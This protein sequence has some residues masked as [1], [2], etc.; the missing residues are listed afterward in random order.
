MARFATREGIFQFSL[1]EKQVHFE[2][3]LQAAS[4]ADLKI[5]SRLLLLAR[6]VK[7]QNR[8]LNK[9]G[10]ALWLLIE[11][12]VARARESRSGIDRTVVKIAFLSNLGSR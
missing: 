5:S 6:I 1:E 11:F 2:I 10:S 7:E 9:E 8:I 12:E 4:E 3:N